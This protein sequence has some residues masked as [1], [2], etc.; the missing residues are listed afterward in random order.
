MSRSH[1]AR[2]PRPVYAN[3]YVRAMEGATRLR[4]EIRAE[5][6]AKYQAAFIAFR[7]GNGCV[8]AWR[9]LADALNLAEQI[10]E[11]GIVCDRASKDRIAAGHEV[12]GTVIGRVEERRSWTLYAAE[13]QTLEDAL[14]MFSAQLDYVSVLEFENAEKRVFDRIS[15]ALA[16]NASPGTTIVQAPIEPVSKGST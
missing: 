15:A 13:I 9:E 2:R 14:W 16:G 12:L 8:D 3:S 11:Y 1:K 5:R 4:P 7:T 6:R 10:A